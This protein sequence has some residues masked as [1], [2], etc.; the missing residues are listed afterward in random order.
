MATRRPKKTKSTRSRKP[1]LTRRLTRRRTRR[2][3]GGDFP[4]ADFQCHQIQEQIRLLDQQVGTRRLQRNPLVHLVKSI[5]DRVTR[6]IL[7]AKLESCKNNSA[8][9]RNSYKKLQQLAANNGEA[10][11]SFLNPAKYL[12]YKLNQSMPRV[13]TGIEHLPESD[14]VYPVTSPVV[15]KTK[16]PDVVFQPTIEGIANLVQHASLSDMNALKKTVEKQIRSG[17]AD[18]IKDPKV[19]KENMAHLYEEGTKAASVLASIANNLYNVYKATPGTQSLQQAVDR[20]MQGIRTSSGGSR[21]KR[22]K[23]TRS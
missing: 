11:P 14:P 16:S 1:R 19:A 3:R 22:K 23:Y 4:G 7:S 18:A 5:P 6:L 20:S 10:P 9:A 17:I 12:A 15:G 21:K 13:R 8:V 2:Q